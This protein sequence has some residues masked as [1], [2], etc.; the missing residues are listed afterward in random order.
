MDVLLLSFVTAALAE[1]GDKSQW[2]V[3]A[4][5]LHFRRPGAVLAGVAAG[6]LG[7]SLMAAAA[8]AFVHDLVALRSASLLV[9]LALAF[10]GIAG[11]IRNSAPQAPE[12]AGKGAFAASAA[13][14]FAAELADKTQF[15]TFGL[16]AQFDSLTL[17]A[18]GATAGMVAAAVPAVLAP[19]ALRDAVPLKALRI[20]AACL[21]LLAA[22]FVAANALRLV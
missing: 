1:I 6:A 8:G 17:A 21:F 20:G 13:A 16:A 7:A 9:A 18:A 19:E 22:F 14:F 10:A 11:L 15:L 4:L 12:S 5:A 3:L 2:I